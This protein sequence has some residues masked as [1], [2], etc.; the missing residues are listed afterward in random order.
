MAERRV[1]MKKRQRT[2]NWRIFSLFCGVILLLTLFPN[3]AYAAY[4][5]NELGQ[6]VTIEVEE[7][8]DEDSTSVRNPDVE[9]YT[10]GCQQS[11]SVSFKKVS[12]SDGKRPG[13]WVRITVT[14]KP[15]RGE[16]LGNFAISQENQDGNIEIHS[17]EAEI[18]EAEVI[19]QSDKLVKIQFE[20]QYK[21]QLPI[22]IE[23]L[24]YNGRRVTWTK[25]SYVKNET[26]EYVV[27]IYTGKWG[28]ALD[29]IT[30]GKEDSCSI[31]IEDYDSSLYP[32]R[33][34]YL[35]FYLSSNVSGVSDSNIYTSPTYYYGTSNNIP[36][37]PPNDPSSPT[38]PQPGPSYCYPT[39]IGWGKNSDDKWV[40]YKQDGTL[41]TSWINV[42]SQ[43]HQNNR[44]YYL[45]DDGTMATGWLDWNGSRYYL[46]GKDSDGSMLQKQWLKIN[47]AYWYYFGDNGAMYRNG[48]KMI[49][50]DYYYFYEDGVMA[51]N[52]CIDG[53][54]VNSEGRR[55]P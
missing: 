9:V 10:Q 52:T 37:N 47:D 5:C 51:A 33:S 3:K 38:Y 23:N 2:S 8:S 20:Y 17:R 45:N 41:E 13:D 35:E 43:L 29:E 54:Y 16:T 7:N 19:Q 39:N 28:E 4:Q 14:I 6:G 49:G 36:N 24:K 44:W 11:G 27:T 55:I 21:G 31:D 15:E 46:F 18:S 25:S 26:A 42:W 53:W 40:Y 30:I 22:R 50:Y 34:F 48:W 12:S 32:N 1:I